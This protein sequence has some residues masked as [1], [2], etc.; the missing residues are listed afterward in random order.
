MAERSEVKHSAL[1]HVGITTGKIDEMVLWYS[2]VLGMKINFEKVNPAGN[3][4]GV[5]A[6]WVTN[7]KAN[8]RI[9]LIGIPGLP[10][11]ETGR[12]RSSIRGAEGHPLELRPRLEICFAAF[13]L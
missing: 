3:L 6:A 8:H 12:P 13:G 5:K 11:A 1:H 10:V 7:D 4:L 2:K 9:A